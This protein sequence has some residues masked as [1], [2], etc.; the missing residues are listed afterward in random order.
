[1]PTTALAPVI[2]VQGDK[3]VNCH[4]CIAACPV[5]HCNDGSGAHV[6]IDAD[7]CIGCGACVTACHHHARTVIDDDARFAAD[8]A[9]GVPIVAIVAPAVAAVFPDQWLR[10]NG[11]LRRAGVRAVFDVAYGAELTV[12]SYLEHLERNRPRLVIAQPC[13]A[14]VSYIEIYRPELLPYLAPA[15]SPMLHTAR[16]IRRYHPEHRDCR[17]AVLSPCAAK[18]REFDETGVCDYHVTFR[19]VQERIARTGGLDGCPEVDYDNP[20]P[21]RAAAFSTPGGLLATARRWGGDAIAARQ[22]EGGHAVYPY[23]DQLPES[24]RRD[25][26]PRLIDCLNC[27]LGCNAGPGTANHEVPRDRLEA[28]VAR[29]ARSLHERHA[30]AAGRSGGDAAIQR[31]IAKDLATRW[32]PGLYDRTY[33]DRSGN[34]GIAEPDDG[35]RAAIYRRMEKRDAQDELDCGGCGYGSCRGMAV[36][37]HNGLNRPENCHL[38]KRRRIEDLALR[39]ADMRTVGHNALQMGAGMEQMSHS[40]GDIA[41]NAQ[42]ALRSAQEGNRLAAEAD[43]AMQRLSQA[44]QHVVELTGS[45]ARIAHQTRLLALNASIEAA[46]SGEAGR[47]FAVVA[48]EV[49]QLANL[50]QETTGRVGAGVAAIQQESAAVARSLGELRA[51][52]HQIEGSQASISAAVE[53]Q[54]SATRSMSSTVQEISS[55]VNRRIAD[56][57]GYAAS[58]GIDLAGLGT[59]SA[60]PPAQ[61]RPG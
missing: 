14:I 28:G 27:E 60:V 17:I 23:L 1:M 25:E 24:L 59:A 41:R 38:Y 21:E 33:V 37:I 26:A 8:L 39:A 47:G 7:T 56:I 2:A 49:R 50:V 22:I 6:E 44:G 20:P 4:A 42:E 40:V 36:A 29:R 45:I 61:P 10:F 34:R 58:S 18:R 12:K 46:R 16:M 53:Q 52:T 31:R 57:T 55:D 30:A 3:C 19:A 43:A 51:A 5:K 15:D 54:A 9:A 35:Q 11:W 13:P 48:A 32:E